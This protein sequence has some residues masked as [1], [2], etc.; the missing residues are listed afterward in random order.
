MNFYKQWFDH[1]LSPAMKELNKKLLRWKTEPDLWLSCCGLPFSPPASS[2][3]SSSFQLVTVMALRTATGGRIESVCI[4]QDQ[5]PAE[6]LF[7]PSLQTSSSAC[8]PAQRLLRWLAWA[9]Q[10]CVISRLQ[11]GQEQSFLAC[12]P[13]SC[14]PPGQIKHFVLKD[15]ICCPSAPFP[16]NRRG[17]QYHIAKAQDQPRRRQS[18]NQACGCPILSQ[19]QWYG[20]Q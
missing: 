13:Y 17:L 14:L 9:H 20:A 6:T 7:P 15:G 8:L 16:V 10:A 5:V 19:A 4:G 2:R 1:N 12:R 18:R 3:C 11:P